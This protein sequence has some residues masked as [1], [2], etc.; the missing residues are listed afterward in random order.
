MGTKDVNK[1]PVG[2]QKGKILTEGVFAVFV[3]YSY[4][5]PLDKQSETKEKMTGW[6]KRIEKRI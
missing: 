4:I 3:R 6:L 2:P 5:F 1:T